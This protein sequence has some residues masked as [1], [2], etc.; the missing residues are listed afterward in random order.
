MGDININ[1]VDKR[2]YSELTVISQSTTKCNVFE[3]H[4]IS[5]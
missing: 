1:K 4:A 3:D 5:L 2:F